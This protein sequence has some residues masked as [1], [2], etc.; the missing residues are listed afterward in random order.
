MCHHGQE[1]P[2][3]EKLPRILAFLGG[4]LHLI[5][6]EY[7]AINNSKQQVKPPGVP[8]RM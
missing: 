3:K 6:N 2:L 7:K 4:I 1:N 5:V 8:H